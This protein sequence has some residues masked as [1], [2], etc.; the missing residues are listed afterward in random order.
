MTANVFRRASWLILATASLGIPPAQGSSTLAGLRVPVGAVEAGRSGAA[1][2][3]A[4]EVGAVR[5]NP[6]A[7]VGAEGFELEVCGVEWFAGMTITSAL[8]TW[9]AAGGRWT[10][11]V[12]DVD[13]G[14]FERRGEEPTT[15]PDGIFS[16][17]DVEV[18]LCY[19]RELPWWNG[20]FGATIRGVAETIDTDRAL[21]ADV[22][23]GVTMVGSAAGLPV[24]VGLTVRHL[25]PGFGPGADPLPKTWATGARLGDRD[26]RMAV[27][28]D[29]ERVEG[30][31]TGAQLGL[32]AEVATGLRIRGGHGIGV[33]GE[34]LSAGFDMGVGAA[35][36]EV[37]V[38][39]AFTELKFD[40]GSA[41]RIQFSIA[42]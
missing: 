4:G 29:V 21:G 42:F 9:P 32:Q 11:W 19:G 35:G 6:A 22:D 3:A 8:V 41:H 7:G 39:Y 13:L 26:G 33:E 38:A 17:S 15:N 37:N 18:A 24:S 16:A 40:L 25:G 28:G 10:A 30:A 31:G 12:T 5:Y 36:S 14:E 34:G 23:L 27:Y 2:G 1:V 20:S